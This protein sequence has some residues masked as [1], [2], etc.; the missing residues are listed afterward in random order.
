LLI[1]ATERPAATFGGEEL[2]PTPFAKAAA[3]LE[4]ILKNL[5]FVDGN[6]RTGWLGCIIVLRLYNYRFTLTEEQA[7]NFVIK[8]VSTHTGFEDIVEYIECNTKR[9]IV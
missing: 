6:K 4:S 3:I 5:P 9:L 7:Y 2:Y 8:V 1:I